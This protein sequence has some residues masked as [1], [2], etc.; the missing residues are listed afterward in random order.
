MSRRP[1]LVPL[2]LVSVAAAIAFLAGCSGGSSS[3]APK[4]Q[5]ALTAIGQG[6]KSA[7]PYSCPATGTIVYVADVAVNTVNV[8]KGQF[9][10]QAACGQITTGLSEPGGMVV[11]TTTHDLYV[12][13]FGGANVQVYHRGQ[14]TPYNTY[15]DPSVQDVADV[16]V[17][18]D[19]T[20]FAA[21]FHKRNRT[22]RGSISTWVG[23]PNGGTFVGNF[24]MA[25][26]RDGYNVTVNKNGEVYFTEVT[27][28]QS[29]ALWKMRCPAGVCG[30]QTRIAG[31]VFEFPGGMQFNDRGNLVAID[32]AGIADTFNLPNPNPRTFPLAGQPDAMA[33]SG[34]DHHLFVADYR[35]HDAAE[36]SY[37]SGKLI[38]TVQG[39]PVGLPDGIAID[40]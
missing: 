7:T 18:P 29:G 20:V 28:H 17:A 19:G 25:I 32:Q 1:I 27:K 11:Q 16:A 10:G 34:L 40:P 31:V 3:I 24:P 4:P 15:T 8:Y 30:A 38:G 14:T 37:P 21:N 13:N 35:N 5:G 6:N 23:G 12:S 9:A 39:N 33:L 36:Y 22:E 2:Q 26:S